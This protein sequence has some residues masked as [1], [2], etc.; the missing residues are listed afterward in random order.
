MKHPNGKRE[1]KD[2]ESSQ[3]QAWRYTLNGL[4]L[5]KHP[6]TL[7]SMDQKEGV[8]RKNKSQRI[9]T[10]VVANEPLNNRSN[11]EYQSTHLLLA[12]HKKQ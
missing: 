3:S 1:V 4:E 12:T 5:G 10:S 11:S 2:E 8:V 9:K 6:A 7:E